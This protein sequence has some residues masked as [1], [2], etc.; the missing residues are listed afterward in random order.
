MALLDVNLRSSAAIGR[1]SA[2][3]AIVPEGKEGPFPVLYLLHGLSDDNTAWTRRTSIERYVEGLP[4][5]VVMP[6][7]Q[8]SWYVDA[9]GK[10]NENYETYIATEL[11]GFV[12]R[13]FHTIPEARGRAIAGLSMGGYGSLLLAVK[14]PDIFSVA[15]SFSGA[16][17]MAAQ[18]PDRDS[19]WYR[20]LALV[21]G[22]EIAGTS[23]S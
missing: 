8:R 9:V 3:T 4:L 1:M 14:H 19:D 18:N 2:F 6:N 21:F 12:D 10:R 11:V 15:H 17:N 13:T 5:I 7:G 22:P 20:E 16:V 23:I